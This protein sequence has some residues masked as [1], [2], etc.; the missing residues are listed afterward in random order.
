MSTR[1]VA[2]SVLGLCIVS[3]CSVSLWCVF[4]IKITSVILKIVALH[5]VKGGNGLHVHMQHAS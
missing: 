2:D 4:R 1:L 3:H 5:A